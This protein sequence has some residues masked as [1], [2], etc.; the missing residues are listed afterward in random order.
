[1]KMALDVESLDDIAER[2]RTLIHPETPTTL[3]DKL[4][5]LPNSP[6]SAALPKTIAAKDAPCKQAIHRTSRTEGRE[7]TC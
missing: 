1:M 6:R 4:K 7:S 3:M 5:L 2:I